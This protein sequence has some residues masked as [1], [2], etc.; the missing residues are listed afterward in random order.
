[1]LKEE[2]VLKNIKDFVDKR[3]SVHN[4]N[5]QDFKVSKNQSSG[6]G[7][8]KSGRG[9]SSNIQKNRAKVSIALLEPVIS[10]ICYKYNENP[11]EWK[12]KQLDD[13]DQIAA[14]IDNIL[15][16]P[17]LKF[18]IGTALRESIIDGI[19]YMLVYQKEGKI[20][21]SRLN[22]FNVMYGD[23]EYSDGSDV[24][25]V[26]YLDKKNAGKDYRKTDMGIAFTS[27]LEL[28]KNEIPVLTYWRK[29]GDKV[30]TYKI[31]NDK[32]V[33]K[34]EEELGSIPIVR[35]YGK[36]VYLNFER[37]WRGFYYLVKDTL[38]NIDLTLS[39]IQERIVCAP[40]TNYLIA[41]ESIGKNL[42]NWTNIEG[43]PKN[44]QTY[45][46][47]DAN[48]SQLLPAPIKQNLA[49]DLTDLLAQL[50]ADRSLIGEIL[51]T[52]AGDEKAGETAEAVLLRREAKDTAV[53]E[54]IKNLLDSCYRIKELIEKYQGVELIL[55]ADLFEKAKQ[56]ADLEKVIALVNVMNQN[57]LAHAAFPVLISL[58]DIDMSHKQTLIQQLEQQAQQNQ[59]TQ[60]KIQMLE[61][62]NQQLSAGIEMEVQSAEIKRQ[63]DMT[64]KQMD[65]AVKQEEIKLGWAKIELEQA[66]LQLSNIKDIRQETADNTRIQGDLMLRG[67]ELN[68]DFLM[69]QNEILN[70]GIV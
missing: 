69:K 24:K 46:A 9:K 26:L 51:G 6:N 58:T 27:V 35:I 29:E 43:F 57:P 23:C 12:I 50:E 20:K 60:Q 28:K 19:S 36:E 56:N 68:Q 47:V 48:T 11:F 70:R 54:P 5:V 33:D 44:I 14:K 45:K 64:L 62:Q 15:D 61:Q 55:Q 38:K 13:N 30:Q 65:L 7:F 2:E 53:N 32:V 8:S 49:I 31:E 16:M 18:Q 4:L 37:N 21:F 67:R 34:S 41:E 40:N 42:E 3:S 52:A 59:E 25:E 22:N 17:E 66:K 10:N 39:L 63:S 1:M